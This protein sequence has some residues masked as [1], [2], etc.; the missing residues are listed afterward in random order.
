M[1]LI[2][3]TQFVHKIAINWSRLS[4]KTQ[5]L[6]KYLAFSSLFYVT[7]CLSFLNAT[8]TLAFSFSQSYGWPI[9]TS[10]SQGSL[11]VAVV[12]EDY[13]LCIFTVFWKNSIIIRSNLNHRK[14]AT[15]KISLVL[16]YNFHIRIRIYPFICF[17]I[18]SWLGCQNSQVASKFFHPSSGSPDIMTCGILWPD[19]IL[20]LCW[21]EN[22]RKVKQMGHNAREVTT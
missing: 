18:T 6:S 21:A 7:K 13:R 16:W 2:G 9:L 22:R 8:T 12:M 1:Q 5:D 15:A 17:C 20:S 3:F 14:R 4:I 11:W 19:P 10:Y